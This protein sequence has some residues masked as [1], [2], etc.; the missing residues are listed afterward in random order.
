MEAMR[1]SYCCTELVDALGVSRSGFH[2]HQ[3]KQQRPRRQE[4]K[5]LLQQITPIFV[6]SRRSYGSPRIMHAL[7]KRGLR[8]GKTRIARL[9]REN[10]LRPKQKRRFR[11]QTTQSDDKM[12]TAPN[13]LSKIP[14]P[15]RPGQI[16]IADITYI[17]TMEGWLYL[18][19]ILD[20]RSRRCIGWQSDDS[21]DTSLVTRAWTKA[22]KNQRPAP[23][24]LHHSDRGV[25]YA[26][27]DFR[28]LLHSARVTASMSRKANCYDNATMES[29]WATLKT[30]CFDSFIPQTKAQ[31]ALMLFDYIECFY[32]RSRLHSSL[33][34]QS[35]L[36]FETQFKNLNN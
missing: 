17:Q 18:A 26:S 31:A 29:F 15:D 19:A 13:W 25:Q 27:S 7:R 33:A 1:T 6:A 3:Q 5:E 32:N 16:W 8:H 24:L 11:P 2:A 20:Y 35:P 28:A 36:E 23:G 10:G 30:E 12:P 14:N 4:D 9:M 34:Y 22:W 21:L